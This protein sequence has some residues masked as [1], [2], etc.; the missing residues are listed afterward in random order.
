[1]KILHLGY[2]DKLGGAAIAMMRLHY[3]L[4]KLGVNSKVLVA[5]KKTD[6]PNVIGPKNQFER[7]LNELKIK[8]ARQKKYIFN[9]DGKY[10]HSINFFNS[11][12]VDKIN[13]INPDIVNLHWINNELISIKQISKINYP[14]IWTFNDMWPMCGGEHYSDNRR[15]IEGYNKNNREIKEKGIDLNR[16]IWEA[17]KKFWKKKIDEVIC[18]SNWLKMK[19]DESLLFRHTKIKHIPCAIDVDLWKPL[20]KKLVRKKLNLPLDKKIL[21]FISTNGV[22]DYRK[23]FSFIENYLKNNKGK[24]RNIVLLT[25]GINSKFKKNNNIININKFFNGDPQKLTKLYSAADIILTPSKL[26]AFGQVAIEAASC[27]TPAIGF[28]NTGLEDAIIHKKTGYLC[29]YLDQRDFS[30]GLNWIVDK[31]NVD[32]NYF[33]LNSMN[34]VKNTFSSKI[35]AKQYIDVYKKYIN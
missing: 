10:S 33:K 11:S 17:K 9:H 20:N 5:E 19:A 29:K 8:I 24:T 16:L 34:F 27:G 18:I 7:S 28:R 3:S 22:N 32:K 30:N 1:M 26:E 31:I 15:F 25:I 4:L 2:S 12:V 6:D 21:L 14:I 23:G 13:D 35:I